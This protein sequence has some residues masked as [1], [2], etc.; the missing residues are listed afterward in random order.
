M[1]IFNN[2]TIKKIQEGFKK[3]YGHKDPEV[4]IED[5][6][7]ILYEEDI[8]K[9]DTL[10]KNQDDKYII[11]M[12]P[13]DKWETGFSGDPYIKVIQGKNYT[14]AGFIIRIL[15]KSG[16]TKIHSTAGKDDLTINSDVRKWIIK[17]LKKP[18]TNQKY[19]G[20]TVYDAAWKFVK[21]FA[22]AR[23]EKAADYIP[24][25]DFV[26]MFKANNK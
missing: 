8:L 22:D 6:E 5:S 7:I 19:S 23:G 3:K 17:T 14:Q 16:K 21:E 4:I 15:L 1:A 13:R 20:L 10:Y 2:E 25:D 24:Y 11:E 26:K 18:C 12:H 9:E